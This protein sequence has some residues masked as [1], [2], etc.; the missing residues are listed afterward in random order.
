M[1]DTSDTRVAGNGDTVASGLFVHRAELE[2]AERFA[3]FSDAILQKEQRTFRVNFDED[4]NDEQ[5]RE[6]H[7]KPKQCHDAVE[8]PLEK[9]SYFVFIFLHVAWPPC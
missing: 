1:A 2:D 5:Y 7:N 8:A 9:E 3:V 4:G 6:E